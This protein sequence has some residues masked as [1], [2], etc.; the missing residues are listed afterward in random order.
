VNGESAWQD[1]GVHVSGS[2]ARAL[3]RAFARAWRNAW[4]RRER[5][6]GRTKVWLRHAL[7]LLNTTRTERRKRYT[8]LLHKIRKAKT[9]V[10][11]T[12]AYFSP[13]L[14]LTRTLVRAARAGVDVRILLPHSSD[15]FFMPWVS[16][17]FYE[18]LLS[19][20]IRIY[21]YLPTFLHAKSWILDDWAMVGSSNL[22]YR[23]L[24]HDLEADIVLSRPE[25]VRSVLE[26]FET[27]LSRSKEVTITDLTRQPLWRRLLSWFFLF[28]RYWL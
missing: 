21:E 4:G 12:N 9:R 8:E 27:H 28:F 3:E 16:E 1:M 5:E 10:W 22:N 2:G 15:V 6:S 17:A 14:R 19:E 18:H 24:L 11:I 13:H 23:S 7:V 25:S 20:G 26:R